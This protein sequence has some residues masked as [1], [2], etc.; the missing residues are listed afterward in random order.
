MRVFII[1]SSIPQYGDDLPSIIVGTALLIIRP[2]EARKKKRFYDTSGGMTNDYLF[3]TP[4]RRLTTIG[5]NNKGKKNRG[6]KT[7][8]HV[9]TSARRGQRRDRSRSGPHGQYVIGVFARISTSHKVSRGSGRW[10][11]RGTSSQR[12]LS[13]T[14]TYTSDTAVVVV[15]QAGGGGSDRGLIKCFVLLTVDALT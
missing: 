11:F 6:K 10:S 7:V 1:Y 9:N 5:I 14:F 2:G 12:S 13:G 4:P 8:V 15:R 3:I